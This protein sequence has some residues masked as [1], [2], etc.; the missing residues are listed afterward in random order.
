MDDEKTSSEAK[1]DYVADILE[2]I[3]SPNPTGELELALDFIESK[4][5]GHDYLKY[6]RDYQHDREL[7]FDIIEG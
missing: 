5:L 2:V 6:R 7:P 1:T 4:G 3:R